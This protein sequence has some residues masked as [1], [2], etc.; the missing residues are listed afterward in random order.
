MPRRRKGAWLLG[1]AQG[2]PAAGLISEARPPKKK[3][4]KNSNLRMATA[5]SSCASTWLANT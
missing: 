4:R 5:Y 3:S 2:R 1:T